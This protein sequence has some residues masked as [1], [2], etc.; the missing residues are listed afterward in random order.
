LG[1]E[2]D[3]VPHHCSI[4]L[5]SFYPIVP[6]EGSLEDFANKVNALRDALRKTNNRRQETLTQMTQND[7]RL[8]VTKM[9]CG[10]RSA[11]QTVLRSIGL[12]GGIQTSHIER[13]NLTIRPF[14]LMAE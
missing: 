13:L 14:F 3:L 2:H 11:L 9:L 8:A 1:I 10:E 4:S 7:W 12:S 6:S 5:R